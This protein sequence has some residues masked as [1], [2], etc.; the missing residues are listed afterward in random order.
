VKDALF[1]S[2]SLSLKTVQTV[3]ENSSF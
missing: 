1:S 2:S 3:T